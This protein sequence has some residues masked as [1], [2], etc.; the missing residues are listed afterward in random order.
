MK[1]R[2]KLWIR[3][4]ASTTINFPQESSQHCILYR[5]LFMYQSINV[6][7]VEFASRIEISSRLSFDLS[8]GPTT[9]ATCSHKSASMQEVN[10]RF[11]LLM[12]LLTSARNNANVFSFFFFF[13][14]FSTAFLNTPLCRARARKQRCS[15]AEEHRSR[16]FSF[17]DAVV[18]QPSRVVIG[19]S[20]ERR[21]KRGC[22]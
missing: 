8:V 6:L 7:N 12:S 10:H 3:G 9:R 14:L 17:R 15:S 2:D 18:S 5:V 20:V 16:R 4:V 13:P 22:K 1:W 19:T 21:E 11:P